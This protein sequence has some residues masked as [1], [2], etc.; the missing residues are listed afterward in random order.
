MTSFQVCSL[1][2]RLNKGK[3]LFSKAQAYMFALKV[4]LV[5]LKVIHFDLSYLPRHTRLRDEKR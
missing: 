3:L 2:S 1:N 4:Y 5:T